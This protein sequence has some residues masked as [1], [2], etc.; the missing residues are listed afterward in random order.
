MNGTLIPTNGDPAIPLVKPRILIGRQPDC[1]IRLPFPNVSSRHAEMRFHKG[2]W[3]IVDRRSSNGTKV[4]GDK[5]ERKRLR[6][7]DEVTFARKYSFRIE[8]VPEAKEAPA[9]ELDVII[10]K[11]TDDEKMDLFS[12]SLLE[13][14]GL[15]KRLEED[16]I[17]PD[18]FFEDEDNGKRETLSE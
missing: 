9:D 12:Q 15:A 13:R 3:V 6:P 1:D 16:L 10:K 14:A 17:D 7:G 11:K 8:Y 18:L 4:N 2:W 5:I